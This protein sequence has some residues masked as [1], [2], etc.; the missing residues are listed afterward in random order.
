MF[1]RDLVE[2]DGPRY[3]RLVNEDN[4]PSYKRPISVADDHYSENLKDDFPIAKDVYIAYATMP[5]KPYYVK[6]RVDITRNY[7]TRFQHT[8]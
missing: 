4:Y 6:N 5:G 7:L 2:V 3:V 8:A 1:P